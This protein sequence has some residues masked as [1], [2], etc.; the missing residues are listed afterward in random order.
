MTSPPFSSTSY[1]CMRQISGIRNRSYHTEL[2][3]QLFA[4]QFRIR[5]AVLPMMSL[6]R[7]ADVGL[8]RTRCS[9]KLFVSW[10]CEAQ[11]YQ[12]VLVS[13][14]TARLGSGVRCLHTGGN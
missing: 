5:V 14:L 8:E 11:N 13:R 3:V 6:A 10:T 12:N 9:H 7:K 2:L 4:R 1:F